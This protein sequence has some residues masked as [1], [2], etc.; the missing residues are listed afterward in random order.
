MWS[1]IV[2][3]IAFFA[4]HYVGRRKLLPK[5]DQLSLDLEKSWRDLQE[6]KLTQEV[7]IVSLERDLAEQTK[8]RSRAEAELENAKRREAANSSD[9]TTEA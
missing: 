4:G 9:T 2:A 6:A 1:L 5:L 3:A 8:R 7:R